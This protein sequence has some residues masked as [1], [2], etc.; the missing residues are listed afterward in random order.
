MTPSFIEEI[1]K[2]VIFVFFLFLAF[3]LGTVYGADH[4]ITLER[5]M[6]NYDTKR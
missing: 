4:G 5:N 6:M 1:V 3:E 2:F